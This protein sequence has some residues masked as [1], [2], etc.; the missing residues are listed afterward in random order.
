VHPDSPTAHDNI[1][2]ALVRL[3]RT[4]EAIEHFKEAVRLD[5]NFA[6]GHHRLGVSLL[7]QKKFDEAV[8]HLRDVVRLTPGAASAHGD[9][10]R[11]LVKRGRIA[12]AAAHF[13]ET[14]RLDPRHASAHNSLAW[15]L[16]AYDVPRPPDTADAITLAQRACELTGQKDPAA[17]DTLAA[18][19]AAAGRFREA[20]ATA[21]QALALATS[22]QHE[23]LADRIRARLRLYGAGR[24][25]R[26]RPTTT[27]PAEP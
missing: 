13:A 24:P 27:V 25:Y 11:A 26:E 7:S 5:P 19:Y 8:V 20:V 3:N 23:A 16:A 6:E 22:P 15:I 18:A 2:M 14:V 12:E 1:G 21:R 9:L 10:A 17:L 4:D